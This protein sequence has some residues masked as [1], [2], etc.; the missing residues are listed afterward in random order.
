MPFEIDPA[1]A[2]FLKRALGE[3]EVVLILGAGASF[4]SRNKRGEPVKIGDAL[5]ELIAQQAGFNYAKEKLAVVLSAARPILGDEKL[6]SIYKNEYLDTTPADDLRALSNFTWRRIYTWNIDDAINNS[7]GTRVQRHHYYNGMS[8]AVVDSDNI[9]NLQIIK[10]HGD[11][12]NPA[13][14]FIMTE[15]DYARALAQGNHAWYR[16][17]A[18][19]Y[20]SYTP[21]FIGSRLEEPILAA[22]LERAKQSPSDEMGRGYVITPDKLTGLEKSALRAR[23]LVHVCATLDDFGRWLTSEWASGITPREVL[24]TTH[25]FKI[26]DLQNKISNADLE[27][28]R[29]LYP[30]DMDKIHARASSMSASDAN[31]EARRFLRGFP[32]TWDVAASE[33]P[34]WLSPTTDLLNSLRTS[35]ESGERMFVV[36]GQAGSGKSTAVMQSLIKYGRENKDIPIYE[37]TGEI[38]SVRSALSIIQRLHEK[39]AIVYISDLFIFGDQLADD[40]LSFP[41]GRITVVATARLSEW[42]EH[43][44]RRFGDLSKRHDF[45]R[46]TKSDYQPIIDRLLKFVPAPAFMSLSPKDRLARFT[47]SQEQLLIA[48]REATFSQNFSDIITN[49]Y[50]KL[51]DNDTRS[52]LLIVGLATAARV[53]IDP[54]NAREAY[55]RLPRKRTFEEAEQALDGIVSRLPNGRLFARHEVYVRHIIDEVV[56]IDDILD[57]LISITSTYTKYPIPVVRNVSKIEAALFRFCWNH[58]FVFEQCKKRNQPHDG[59]RLY[60]TFEVEFQLD[61]HFWLQYGLYL[62]ECRRYDDALTMLKRSIEAYP[63]N[64]FAIHAYAELQFQVAM[65]RPEYDSITRDLIGDAVKSLE[66]LDS[67][68]DDEIDQYP[69]VTLS[70]LH[71]GSLIKFAQMEDATRFGKIYYERLK[72]LEKNTYGDRVTNAKERIFKFVTLGDWDIRSRVTEPKRGRKR[73][74]R[75]RQSRT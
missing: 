71:V 25:N 33:I 14:K 62:S 70:N 18:Q 48:M 57:M 5:A 72:Q 73:P 24:S 22:E 52:L 67:R 66:Q 15:A 51:P 31:R 34:V 58:K 54:G 2:T 47:S 12:L 8:D 59:E 68:P 23:G 13:H 32:P 20:L 42:R 35:V 44:E 45:S 41:R 64:P 49:E 11:I 19:D 50:E 60:S 16:K 55:V 40:I 69:L 37:L 30:R 43:L 17:L 26:E 56:N 6:I 28:A 9:S 3:G 27:S 10:L 61:G 7:L 38:K 53:G 36:T 75:R 21:V 46:F 65:K 39:N 74:R 4:S 29:A 63:G 1:D